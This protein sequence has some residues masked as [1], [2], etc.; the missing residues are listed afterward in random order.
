MYDNQLI[1]KQIMKMQ[2]KLVIKLLHIFKYHTR[3]IEF[4]ELH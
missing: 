2:V 4:F 1:F 3:I